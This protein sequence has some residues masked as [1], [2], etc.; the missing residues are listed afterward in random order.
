MEDKE[1][2]ELYWNRD[3]KAIVETDCKYRLYLLTIIRRILQNLE[4]CSETLNDSYLKIW[5]SIPPNYPTCFRAFISK[6]TRNTAID[7]YRMTTKKYKDFIYTVFEDESQQLF[8]KE[9]VEENILNQELGELISDF[10]SERTVL[11]RKIFVGRYFFFYSRKDLACYLNVSENKIRNTIYVL[12]KDL[13]KY[14]V[15]EGYDNYGYE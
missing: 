15:A 3:E 2:V 14:L 13:R 4:D 8:S 12:N 11:E 1:I 7:K 6:I 5:N 9:T 10:L